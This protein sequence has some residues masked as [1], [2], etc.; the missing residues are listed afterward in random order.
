MSAPI[1]GQE[2]GAHG[3]EPLE[4]L[5]LT[6]AVDLG[7]VRKTLKQILNFR[8]GSIVI[9]DKS[10]G[11]PVDIRVNDLLVGEGEIVAGEDSF[12]VRVTRIVEE[13]E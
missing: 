7:R 10:T 12:G 8:P 3:L 5:P 11:E 1:P 6:L 13:D 4:R 9:L 2:T